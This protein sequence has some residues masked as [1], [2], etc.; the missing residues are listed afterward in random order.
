M[1]IQS[2]FEATLNTALWYAR[3]I[4]CLCANSFHSW[5]PCGNMRREV[6]IW[7]TVFLWINLI[8]YWIRSSG[9]TAGME[10]AGG[11]EIF[12]CNNSSPCY[13]AMTRSFNWRWDSKL[14][15]LEKYWVFNRHPSLEMQ[16]GFF[17]P[18]LCCSEFQ[19]KVF[20]AP[21][22]CFNSVLSTGYGHGCNISAPAR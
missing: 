6:G 13:P 12:L 4:G 7:S 16:T 22:R 10:G 17:L 14:E 9:N 15:K 1:G 11:R 8:H 5:K 3:E 21:S 2:R 18:S 19:E 20:R